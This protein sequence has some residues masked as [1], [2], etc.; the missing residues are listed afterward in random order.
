MPTLVTFGHFLIGCVALAGFIW[1][2][3]TVYKQQTRPNRNQFTKPIYTPE[4]VRKMDAPWPKRH[5]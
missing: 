3:I 4:E 5:G 2:F 1:L